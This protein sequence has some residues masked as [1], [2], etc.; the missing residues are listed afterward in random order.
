M[1]HKTI[2]TKEGEELLKDLKEKHTDMESFANAHYQFL[3]ELYFCK[4]KLYQL[5]KN[6]TC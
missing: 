4:D 3:S 5:K 1:T 6:G 2:T